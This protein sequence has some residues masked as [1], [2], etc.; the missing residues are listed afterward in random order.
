MKTKKI[1]ER[2]EKIIQ[3]IADNPNCS[4][5]SIFTKGKIPKSKATKDLIDRLVQEKKIHI[6]KF[7]RRYFVGEPEDEFSHIGNTEWRG[8]MDWIEGLD[9]IRKNMIMELKQKPIYDNQL[10]RRMLEFLKYRAKVLRAEAKKSDDVDIRDTLRIFNLHRQHYEEPSKLT[11]FMLLDAMYWAI[12][13]DKYYLAHQLHSYPTNKKRK[14][15]KEPIGAR[16][17]FETL[18][19]MKKRGAQAYGL[20][21]KDFEKNMKRLTEDPSVWNDRFFAEMDRTLYKNSPELKTVIY[22]EILKKTKLKPSMP[23]YENRKKLL[24]ASK[25]VFPDI[26]IGMTFDLISEKTK[27][28]IRKDFKEMG[29][30]FDE[31]E[32][33]MRK[34]NTIGNLSAET[35][36]KA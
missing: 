29:V 34:I 20:T 32:R 9:E 31:F 33:K 11:E 36:D 28:R 5:D 14:F 13:D 12:E 24:D 27:E 30:D 2:E 3:F 16:R 26:P 4:L 15:H 8:D 17:S 10:S 21:G 1:K 6:R 22:K 25:K 23:D 19:D 7:E 18:L 35:W